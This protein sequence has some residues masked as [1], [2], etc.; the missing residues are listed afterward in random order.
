MALDQETRSKGFTSTEGAALFGYDE[1]LTA[2]AIVRGKVDGR[3]DVPNENYAKGKYFE[4]GLMKWYQ[5]RTGKTVEALFDKT[6]HHP[7]YP[8]V[9]ASPDGLV[10]GESRIVDAK[11]ASSWQ[12]KFWGNTADEAPDRVQF[13]LAI[14]ME[15]MNR[16]CADIALWD[17]N[18]FRII[19]MPRDHALGEFICSGMQQMW[20]QFIVRGEWP[21]IDGSRMS[22]AWL[23]RKWPTHKRPD[24]RPATNEEIEQLRRYGRLK[25]EQKTLTKER[26]LIENQLKEAVADREGL[27]W[28]GGRFTWRR[29]KDAQSMDWESMALALLTNFVKDEQT[30][31]ELLANYTKTKPGLRRIFFKSDEFLDDEE[32]ADAA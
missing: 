19:E 1:E 30:R 31:R 10:I 24:L 23:Q 9:L 28:D 18:T 12:G 15:V 13:Q 21:P 29:A 32:T 22:A 14:A 11:F 27:I 2:G 20:D 3:I 6:F 5:D 17:G 4:S 8:N 16:D 26:D 7:K 25:A